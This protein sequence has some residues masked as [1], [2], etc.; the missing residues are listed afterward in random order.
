MPRSK[1]QKI[2]QDPDK[3][4]VE[5]AVKEII[6]NKNTVRGAAKKY[7]MS[8]SMLCRQVKTFKESGPENYSYETNYAH[9]KVF[10]H[11]EECLLLEYV[12]K[13]SQ[14]HF[15]LTTKKLKELAFQFA[16]INNK[17]YP[18]QWEKNQEAGSEWLCTFKNKFK[19]TISLRKPEGTIL[20]RATSFN[21]ENVMNFFN[22]YTD[23]LQR[24]HFDPSRIYNVDETGVSTVQACPKVFA[25][26]GV[27]QVEA[28][29]SGE[30]G[31]NVTMI[32]AVNAIGNLIPPMFIFPRVK[33]IQM[34]IMRG[35]PQDQLGQQI[36]LVGRTK[37]HLV[38]FWIIS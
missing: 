14:L 23:I 1:K 30:R 11:S 13:A 28:M 4:V 27:K 5:K 19:E 7:G 10:T 9:W 8:R 16:K 31:I 17:K 24:H 2:R 15:G 12:Q 32:A 20:G 37:G 34:A 33:Y 21:R 36:P 22:I 35:A 29:T 38:N 26:R 18:E 3:E 6:A 25:K